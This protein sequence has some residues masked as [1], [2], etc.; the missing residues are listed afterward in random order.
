MQRHN[1]G[2]LLILRYLT[3]ISFLV[4]IPVWS[5]RQSLTQLHC[6]NINKGIFI[7]CVFYI[8]L[9]CGQPTCQNMIEIAYTYAR[10]QF[11]KEIPHGFLNNGIYLKKCQ[12]LISGEK[13]LLITLR[14]KNCNIRNFFEKTLFLYFLTDV[15]HVYV[16]SRKDLCEPYDYE[17]GKNC[18]LK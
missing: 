6:D 14:N 7:H 1:L 4:K 17:M 15:C 11:A 8:I 3:F 12:N 5:P 9:S 13:S 10:T 16:T 2:Y 18:T